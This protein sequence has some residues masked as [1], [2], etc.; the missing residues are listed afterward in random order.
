MKQDDPCER[1][2]STVSLRIAAAA[3]PML[4]QPCNPNAEG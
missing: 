1:I 3:D 2:V 4:L